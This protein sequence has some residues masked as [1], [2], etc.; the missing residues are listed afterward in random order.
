MDESKVSSMSDL[1]TPLW[2][3]EFLRSAFPDLFDPGPISFDYEYYIYPAKID[4]VM[5]F[6]YESQ[7]LDILQNGTYE[8]LDGAVEFLRSVDQ[9]RK[10]YLPSSHLASIR[11]LVSFSLFSFCNKILTSASTDILCR[12]L[13]GCLGA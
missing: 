12:L 3:T 7:L 4:G 8:S 10:D 11:C 13:I 2:M 1:C 5:E 9:L 6:F